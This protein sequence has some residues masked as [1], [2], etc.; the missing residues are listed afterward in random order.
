M[1]ARGL[2]LLGVRSHDQ[3]HSLE[4]FNQEGADIGAALAQS[5]NLFSK[6]PPVAC[7]RPDAQGQERNTQE[8][9]PQVE[10][11]HD[12][13]GARQE[14]DISDPGESPFRGNTLD[15]THVVVDPRDDFPKRGSRVE[16]RRQPLEVP[17]QSQTHV[18]QHLGRNPRIAQPARRVQGKTQGRDPAEQEDDAPEHRRVPPQERAVDQVLGKVG[19]KQCENRTDQTE[20]KDQEKPP[21]IGQYENQRRP[22]ILVESGGAHITDQGKN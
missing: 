21:Q 22:G 6:P 11:E 10:P 12:P 2:A 18:K 9:E 13:D 3:F 16:A 20:P 5:R 15:F 1:E 17:V 7:Q 4:R 19:K 14:Q 8:K